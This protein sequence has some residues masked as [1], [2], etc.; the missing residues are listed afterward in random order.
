MTFGA[1]LLDTLPQ[2]AVLWVAVILLSLATIPW[3]AQWKRK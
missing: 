2:A 3:T 1:A